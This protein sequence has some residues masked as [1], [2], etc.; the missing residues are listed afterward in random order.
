M[1]FFSQEGTSEGSKISNTHERLKKQKSSWSF[2]TNSQNKKSKSV[3]SPK[4]AKTNEVVNKPLFLSKNKA[5]T[6]MCKIF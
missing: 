4:V 3:K 1:I 5:S 6:G 2:L